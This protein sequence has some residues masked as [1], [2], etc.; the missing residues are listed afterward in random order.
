MKIRALTAI[1]CAFMSSSLLA[2][3]QFIDPKDGMF[4][5]S[6][7]VLD[8]AVG[9]MPV[10]I[11]ITDPAVGTGGGAALMFFHESEE[12]ER[13][14]KENPDEVVGLPPSVTAVA[15]AGTSNGSWLTGAFHFGS[16]QED[17]WRYQG[18][19]FYGSFNLKYYVLDAPLDFNIDGL[20]FMQ[21]IDYRLAGSDWFIGAKYS[22]LSS[23]STFDLGNDL[24]QLPPINFDLKDAAV[25]LKV[26]YDSRDSIFTPNDG[27]KAKLSTDFHDQAFGGDV[28]YRK[29][30]LQA[31]YFAPILNDV[32]IG[33]RGDYQTVTDD[34]PYYARPFINMRGIPAMRY[35]GD[36][37]ALMELEA[38]YDITPRWSLIGFTGTGKAIDDGQDFSD[39]DYQSV[40][41]G[42]FRYLVARQ[43]NM[44]AGVDVAKGPEE[45]AYYIT[46]GHAWAL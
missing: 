44:R 46:V 20:Y 23:K 19:L 8:N 38:R 2:F 41:G 13:Q 10:P 1:S 25:E 33:L 26:T 4:D 34:A 29:S 9:F 14:R 36:D 31:N 5:A 32:V 43:L 6:A 15:A 28:S 39:A 16:W 42:G 22:L 11:I 18:G 12:R 35:Q 24:I 7:W 30:R 27:L 45:W 17:T 40:V 21:D 3:D 37:M